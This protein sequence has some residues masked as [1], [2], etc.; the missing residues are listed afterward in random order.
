MSLERAWK[1][2]AGDQKQFSEL[3]YCANEHQNTVSANSSVWRG[4]GDNHGTISCMDK[5]WQHT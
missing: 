5:L 2:A 4:E 1:I 3:A